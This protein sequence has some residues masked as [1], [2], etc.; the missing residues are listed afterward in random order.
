MWAIR[1]KR[2]CENEQIKKSSF[3]SILRTKLTFSG[4]MGDIVSD[5]ILLIFPLQNVKSFS[6][7]IYSVKIKIVLSD[8][9]ES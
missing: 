3:A 8:I 1:H 9:C 2:E 4:T 7:A 5:A 6:Y